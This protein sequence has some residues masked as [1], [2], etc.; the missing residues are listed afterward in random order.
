ML[1]FGI[2]STPIRVQRKTVIPN[3]N[4]VEVETWTD[5]IDEDIMC[6]WKNKFGGEL[7]QAAA[8][9]AKEPAVIKLWYI[10][11]VDPSCRIVRAEDKAIFDIIGVDD[12]E[13]RHQ[14]LSIEVKRYVEG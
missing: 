11:G 1:K 2:M 14:Q 5:I 12:V 10:P 9:N 13:N 6:D 4:D 8:L 7:Y 3:E